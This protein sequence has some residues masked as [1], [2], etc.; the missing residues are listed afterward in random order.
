MV[1]VKKNARSPGVFFYGE[2]PL[3]KNLQLLSDLGEGRNCA[4]QLFLAVSCGNLN[5]DSCQVLRNYRIV[6]TYD[7]NAFVQKFGCHL[8]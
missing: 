8:L 3:F 1:L 5:P 6:E 4:V 2:G 7:I